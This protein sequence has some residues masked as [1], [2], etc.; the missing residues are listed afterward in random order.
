MVT[1][2][3]FLVIIWRGFREDDAFR[4]LVLSALTLLASGTVFYTLSEGWSV[5]NALYFSVLTLTTVGFGDLVP[6]TAASKLF[7]VGYVL[8]GVGLFAAFV[9]EVGRRRLSAKPRGDQSAPD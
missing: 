4:G 2:G 5:V 8:F 1:W 7:T 6:T 3:R 9:T